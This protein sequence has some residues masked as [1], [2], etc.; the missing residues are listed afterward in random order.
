LQGIL[1]ELI[2]SVV[3]C[4]VDVCTPELALVS[5]GFSFLFARLEYT[6]EIIMIRS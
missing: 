5:T 2:I 4:D 3:G 1:I 6:V